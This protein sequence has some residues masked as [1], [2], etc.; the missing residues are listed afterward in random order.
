MHARKM[1]AALQ[2]A[3]VAGHPVLL[4]Y[5]TEAGHMRT[6]PLDATIDAWVFFTI[7]IFHNYVQA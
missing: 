7:F 2:S 5:R 4:H 3:T 6:L 1:A